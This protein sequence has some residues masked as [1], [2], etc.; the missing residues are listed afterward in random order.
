MRLIGSCHCGNIQLALGWE[1][2]PVAIQA[3]ACTCSFCTRHGAVWTAKPDGALEVS[4]AE[5]AMVSRYAFATKTAEFHVCSRCGVVP[6]VTSVV[7]GRMYAV[8]N[9]HTLTNIA[10]EQISVAPVILDG[11][12]EPERLARRKRNWIANVSIRQGRVTG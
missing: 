2:D 3:R 6:V 11:E 5:P 4:I 10:P 1:P 7:D 9:V 8:V 12:L